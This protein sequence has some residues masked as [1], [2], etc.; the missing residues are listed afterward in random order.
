MVD[1]Y[2]LCNFL[3]RL[4]SLVHREFRPKCKLLHKDYTCTREQYIQRFFLEEYNFF[5]EIYLAKNYKY[6]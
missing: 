1:N 4:T 6:D 5:I 2:F 3:S